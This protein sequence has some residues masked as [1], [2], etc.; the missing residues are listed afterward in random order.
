[1]SLTLEQGL[2]GSARYILR[3]IA[4]WVLAARDRQRR[5]AAIR[6]TR[7]ELQALPDWV[8]RDIGICRGD[9]YEL[10]LRVND[11]SRNDAGRSWRLR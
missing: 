7:R 6:R 10:S 4:D 1:M 9:I 5:Y 3:R 2:A 11:P 8:M